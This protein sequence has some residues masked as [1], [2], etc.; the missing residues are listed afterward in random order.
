M[1]T[2]TVVMRDGTERQL[3]ATVGNSVMQILH[4]AGID[5]ILALCGG[6][7][8]CA[9]CHVHVDP[10]W[11][12]RLVPPTNE[13]VELL[14]YTSHYALTSRLSCQIPFT[15]DLDGLRVTAVPDD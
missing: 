10:E 7:R 6:S 8:S 3:K 12:T 13:E 15:S 9:T 14:R 5:G 11:Y 2:I 4:D 1:P